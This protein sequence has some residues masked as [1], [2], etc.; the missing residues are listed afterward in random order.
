MTTAAIAARK[1][2][3]SRAF[4]ARLYAKEIQYEFLK[5][6]RNRMYSLSTIGFPVLFY[7]IFGIANRHAMV[8]G[9]TFAKYLLASYCCFGVIGASLFG[10]GVGFANERSQGW[11]EVKRASP[12]PTM[13]YIVAKLT[14]CIAFGWMVTGSLIVLGVTLGGVHLEA[15]DV[16]SLL[17]LTTLGAIPFASMG[18]LIGLLAPANA[19][20]GIINLI[21]LPMSFGSGLWMPLQLLP[22]WLQKVA[23]FLPAYSFGQMGLEIV[24][25]GDKAAFIGHLTMLLGFT[26]LFLG[27]SWFFF[28]R[29]D[30]RA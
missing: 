4:S 9:I 5:T 8:G 29:A 25:Y 24:G 3:V 19:A 7:F 20:P 10:I 21:Y 26:C 2:H 17:A 27:L 28:H 6:S 15:M 18:L 30:S 12:M 16:V 23:P 22:H 13:A 11:L 1:P 14:A